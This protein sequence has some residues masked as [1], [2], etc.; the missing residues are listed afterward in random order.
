MFKLACIRSYN[1]QGQLTL[2]GV[3]IL[4]APDVWKRFLEVGASSVLAPASVPFD[5]ANPTVRTH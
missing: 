5:E 1:G 3:Q 2:R 4:D